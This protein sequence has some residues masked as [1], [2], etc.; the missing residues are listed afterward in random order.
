MDFDN[1]YRV[2]L[3]TGIDTV[4]QNAVFGSMS[5]LLQLEPTIEHVSVRLYG[6]WT[7]DGLLTDLASEVAAA[8]A[9][10]DPFPAA[11]E[12]DWR[13]LHGEVELARRLLCAPEIDLGDTA[14]RRAG[15]PRLRLSSNPP[16]G[17]LETAQCPA[18]ILYRFTKTKSKTC[19]TPEC[20]V[21]SGT[22]FIVREQKMVDSLLVCD[23]LEALRRPNIV[24]V[25]LLTSDF[26]FT[27]PLVQAALE[28]RIPILLLSN[29]PS[30]TR[31]QI[32]TLEGL[33]IHY[34]GPLTEE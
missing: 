23:L 18:R 32:T 21:T 34:R 9:V 7:E 11:Y 26:D 30:W 22:A 8:L 4:L 1:W 33:G 19:P 2:G 5:E 20:P 16:E 3:T 12:K 29:M 17:C 25:A 10:V 15:P 24:A 13:V 6:G 27:P 14:T 31:D 28:R